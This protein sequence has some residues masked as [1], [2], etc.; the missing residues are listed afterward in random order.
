MDK[1]HSTE[2]RLSATVCAGELEGVSAL[3]YVRCIYLFAE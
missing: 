1:S 3:S 2:L